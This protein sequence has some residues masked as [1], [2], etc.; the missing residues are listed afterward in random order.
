MSGGP[1]DGYQRRASSR[2]MAV[3]DHVHA[4]VLLDL[5]AR[6][7]RRT[8]RILQKEYDTRRAL[9]RMPP[10]PEQRRLRRTLRRAN[11]LTAVYAPAGI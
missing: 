9:Q 8:K 4:L 5:Y 6:V 11:Q 3:R 1:F 7:P 10:L 2:A